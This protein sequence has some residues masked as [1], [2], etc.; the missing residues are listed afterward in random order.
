MP[1]ESRNQTRII[2]YAV[3]GGHVARHW[4]YGLEESFIQVSLLDGDIALNHV[5]RLDST[6][7]PSNPSHFYV[8]LRRE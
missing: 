5:Q 3:T 2:K 8:D 1:Y 4:I 7:K 6:C